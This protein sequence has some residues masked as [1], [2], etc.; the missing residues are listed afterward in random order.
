M[1]ACGEDAGLRLT[2]AMKLSIYLTFSWIFSTGFSFPSSLSVSFSFSSVPHGRDVMRRV[3]LSWLARGREHV[4]LMRGVCMFVC[5]C[6][7]DRSGPESQYV[8]GLMK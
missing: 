1:E 2:S 8:S 7:R 5:L 4:L 3:H 6:R